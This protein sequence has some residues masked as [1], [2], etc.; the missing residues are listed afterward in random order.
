MFHGG[1]YLLITWPEC[2][3]NNNNNNDDILL[4]VQT[5]CQKVQTPDTM[6]PYLMMHCIH[7]FPVYLC[8][9]KLV[10]SPSAKS[11]ITEL[12]QY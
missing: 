9:T 4:I 2:A 3:D 1:T 5:I 7:F 12:E 10:Q 6:I 8:G 11:K